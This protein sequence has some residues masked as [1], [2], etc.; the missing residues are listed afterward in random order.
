[1][2]YSDGE[3]ETVAVLALEMGAKGKILKEISKGFFC[4]VQKI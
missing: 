4:E 1:M 3:L 2:R